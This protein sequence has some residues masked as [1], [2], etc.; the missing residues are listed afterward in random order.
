MGSPLA[1]VIT[2]EIFRVPARRKRKPAVKPSDIPTFHYTAH[3][4]DVR[5]LR[6]AARRKSA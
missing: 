5:W 2:N 4:A 1:R 6:H 3:L